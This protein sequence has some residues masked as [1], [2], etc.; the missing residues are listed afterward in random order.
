[1]RPG[2]AGRTRPGSAR[3]E[4]PDGEQ[5]LVGRLGHLVVAAGQVHD[6]DLAL[7]APGRLDQALGGLG[8]RHLVLLAQGE[9]DW[10][11]QRRHGR[12]AARVAVAGLEAGV[13][14][15]GAVIAGQHAPAQR[16]AGAEYP[17]ACAAGWRQRGAREHIDHADGLLW[18]A[19]C[20]VQQGGRD[21][22]RIG[23]AHQH[24]VADARA[25]P[26]GRFHGD[27]TAPAVADQRGLP[28]ACRIHELADE[29]RRCLHAGGRVTRAAAVARQVYGQH[30]PAVVGQVAA[31]Q[32]PDAVVAQHA[33]DEDGRGL[34][35]VEG[36]AAGIGVDGVA[37][38]IDLHCWCLPCRLT[39]PFQRP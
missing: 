19:Q 21:L 37:L 23:R 8:R 11:L 6:A 20:G 14:Q 22:H 5:R 30:V 28:D 2:P 39:L 29:I 15:V 7:R 34:G 9:Q 18:R 10:T 35:G 4:I 26:G 16:H 32:S 13:Q 1:V 36:L 25:Q 24:Q 3:Q 31:L 27:Q 33:V 38:N 12:L 17:A